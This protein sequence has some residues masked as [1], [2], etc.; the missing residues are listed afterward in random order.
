MLQSLGQLSYIAV[1][2]YHVR[3]YVRTYIL[4]YMYLRTY[5]RMCVRNYM[6][7]YVLYVRTYA[8]VWRLENATELNQLVWNDS[9]YCAC[10]DNVT[11][12]V[13]TPQLVLRTVLG[14]GTFACSVAIIIHGIHE[15]LAGLNCGSVLGTSMLV[16]QSTC[17][18]KMRSG[19]HPH[20]NPVAHCRELSCR[21]YVRIYLLISMQ[22]L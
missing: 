14:E 15:E 17:W 5:K 11:G 1:G 6:C 2:H 13:H 18:A 20:T 4:W 21:I 19:I 7:E 12:Q 9:K 8:Y 16:A 10:H 3:T 22:T